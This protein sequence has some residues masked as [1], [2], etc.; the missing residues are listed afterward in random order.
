VRTFRVRDVLGKPTRGAVLSWGERATDDRGIYRIFGLAPGSYVVQAGGGGAQSS[1]NATDFDAPTYAPSSTRDTAA[2]IQVRGGEEATVDIRYR[3]EQGHV[4]SGAVKTQGSTGSS[5][6]L[7]QVGD[8]I[9]PAGGSYQPP[10]SRGFAIYGVA[11]GEYDL[12]AQESLSATPT[13]YPDVAFSD[14]LRIV[15]KGA[16]VTGLELLPKPLG[17]ISGRITFE[18]A[19]LPE[20]QN[21]RQ[22]LFSE[23]MVALV[24]D[25][26]GPQTDPWPLM[27]LFVGSSAPDKEGAF[28]LRN[29]RPGQYSFSPRFFARY[30]Y[31]R[32]MSIGAGMP[33]ATKQPPSLARDAARNWIP[34]KSGDRL[35][36]LTIILSE[37]A[38]SLRGQIATSEDAKSETDLRVYL[39]PSERDKWD[40]PL[41]YFQSE[42]A[43]DGTFALTNLPPG[44]YRILLQ[45]LQPDVPTSTEKLRLP[46][47]VETRTKIRRAAE[48]SKSELELKPCQ[49]VTDYKLRLN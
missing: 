33:S 10:G 4:I 25:K 40:D 49:N 17:A 45:T 44:K 19:K 35:T 18:P 21:K 5:I 28:V 27:R 9:F 23:T 20:C 32:S 34:V 15:V 3:A 22:P 26:K 36:G 7:T 24:Q 31:L 8:G 43:G 38:A 6:S 46:D 47:A 41:R 14:P 48:T 11:D 30:W 29:I 37:G 2:E 16:D 1:V 39:V 12:T 42:I 13:A